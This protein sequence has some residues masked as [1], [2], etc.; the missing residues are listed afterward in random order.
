MAGTLLRCPSRLQLTYKEIR[1]H[2]ISSKCHF[3]FYWMFSIWILSKNKK[4]Q[5]SCEFSI[6]IM[7]LLPRGA[8]E[9]SASVRT[10]SFHDPFCIGMN[11]CEEPFTSQS[12]ASF[13]PR[14]DSMQPP[15]TDGW[16]SWDFLP[17]RGNRRS[18]LLCPRGKITNPKIWHIT[19]SEASRGLDSFFLKGNNPFFTST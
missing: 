1:G 14:Q 4:D 3:F 8:E 7:K 18:M 15:I 11:F 6:E 10:N 13:V 16:S 17:E 9:R 19:V 5:D 12:D 2:S